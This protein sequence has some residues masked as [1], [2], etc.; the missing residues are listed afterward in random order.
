MRIFHHP[1]YIIGRISRSSTRAE[2][3]GTYIYSIGSVTYRLDSDGAVTTFIA[4]ASFKEATGA[5]SYRCLI[6]YLDRRPVHINASGK[7]DYNKI[8]VNCG[9]NNSYGFSVRPVHSAP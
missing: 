6:F 7:D 9:S 1:G 4:T 5:T 8:C 3:F 2:T